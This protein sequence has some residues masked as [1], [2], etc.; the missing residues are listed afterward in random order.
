MPKLSY[1]HMGLKAFAISVRVNGRQT[2]FIR[3]DT[4]GYYYATQKHRGKSMPTVDAVKTSLE[5]E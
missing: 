2:G 1:E 5:A 3:R 4:D